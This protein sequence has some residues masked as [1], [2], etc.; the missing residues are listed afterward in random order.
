[1]LIADRTEL[2][3]QLAEYT[4]MWENREQESD[5]AERLALGFHEAVAVM[6][7]EAGRMVRNRTGENCVVLGGGVFANVILHERCRELLE[8]DG[9][10]VYVNELVPGNDGGICLGQAWLAAQLI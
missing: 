1:M 6:V 9:F 5:M 3:R 8:Q 7:L 2:I 4:V 10:S